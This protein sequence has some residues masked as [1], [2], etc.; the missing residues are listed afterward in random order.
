MEGRTNTGI[1]VR[2]Y[3]SMNSSARGLHRSETS[4][5]TIRYAEVLLNR[6]EAAYE[7]GLETNNA[8]LKTEAFTYIAQIRDRAGAK[9]YQMKSNPK[10]IGALAV[11]EGGRGY[12]FSVDE[13]LQYIRDERARE[14]ALE[15][16]RIYDLI[17]WRVAD[18]E[19]PQVGGFKPHF[20][21]TYRVLNENKWIFLPEL[22]YGNGRALTFPVR[23]YYNQIPGGVKDKNDLI[24]L[25]DGY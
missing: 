5:K 22:N 23:R 17:R 20:L 3:V 21:R 16:H 14:L 24:I 7:L 12:D 6:A 19:H 4:W 9:P 18:K 1:V 15:N 25:N 2:K 11:E 8:A 10:E 13:N